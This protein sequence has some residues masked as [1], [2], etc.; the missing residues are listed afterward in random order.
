[1]KTVAILFL[2]ILGLAILFGCTQEEKSNTDANS[3]VND[4]DSVW[5]EDNDITIGDMVDS[6]VVTDEN[7]IDSELNSEWV[8]ETS[9]VNT[10]EMI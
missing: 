3:I 1:M 7:V 2:A 5:V 9:E 8:S 6:G 4:A 10:G